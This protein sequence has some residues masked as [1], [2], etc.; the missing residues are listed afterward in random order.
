[1]KFCLYRIWEVYHHHWVPRTIIVWAHPNILLEERIDAEPTHARRVE[2]P[3]SVVVE[4]GLL[5][6]LLGVEPIRRNALVI[7]LLHEDLAVRDVGDTSRQLLT[8]GHGFAT[9]GDR[10]G[11]D[12]AS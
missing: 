7:G 9:V 8:T 5:V 10:E 12:L 3:R 11:G 6:E 1:M 4:S 2:V